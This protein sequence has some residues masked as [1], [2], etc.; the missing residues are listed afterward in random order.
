MNFDGLFHDHLL[1]GHTQELSVAFNIDALRVDL[2]GTAG[3]IAYNLALLGQKP[4]IHAVAG[5]DFDNYKKALEEKGIETTGIKIVEEKTAQA[6]INTDKKNNQITAFYAGALNKADSHPLDLTEKSLV[7]I[8]PNQKE[9]MMAYA[10]YCRTNNHAFIFDPG[11]AMGLFSAEEL[12]KAA[13]GAHVLTLN[14]YEWELWQKQIAIGRTLGL[15]KNIIVTQGENGAIL[16]N[17][18]EE[19]YAAYKVE[20]VE[21]P[22]GSGDAF[23]AGLMHG[24]LQG[25]SLQEAIPLANAV[26]SFCVEKHGTQ[27]HSFTEDEVI[28]RLSH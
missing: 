15:T 4:K 21:D 27:N 26:A 6:F 25:K 22:T 14:E 13:K 2:G 20:K 28:E 16:I 11:Q 7:I 18:K 3:N 19:V 1:K 10:D 24:L 8:S 17:E 23:R 12:E 5:N 9:A